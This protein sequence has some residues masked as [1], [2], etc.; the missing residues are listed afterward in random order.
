MMTNYKKVIEPF[1]VQNTLTFE[2]A[3]VM[4][5]FRAFSWFVFFKGT[6]FSRHVYMGAWA[7]QCGR[8]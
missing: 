1:Y 2:K 3:R 6:F 5:F 8:V 7:I 4:L